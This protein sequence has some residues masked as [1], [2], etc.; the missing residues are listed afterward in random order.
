MQGP[1]GIFHNAF[2]LVN[3]KFP[4][5]GRDG[6]QRIRQ[7]RVPQVL[8]MSLTGKDFARA[9]RSLGR[10]HPVVVRRGVISDGGYHLHVWLVDLG[11]YI[12]A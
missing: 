5:L 4:I 1:L 10:F 12:R 11:S 6:A 2:T 3:W 8:L 7:G 9:V